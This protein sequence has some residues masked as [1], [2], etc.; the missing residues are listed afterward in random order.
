MYNPRGTLDVRELDVE[1]PVTDFA[2][3]AIATDPW[4]LSRR[5]TDGGTRGRKPGVGDASTV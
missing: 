1:V 5:P 2:E 3:G 4:T